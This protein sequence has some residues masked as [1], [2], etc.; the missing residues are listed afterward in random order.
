MSESLAEFFLDNFRARSR[1]CAYRQCRGY[2]MESLAYGDVLDLAARF[3]AE[4]D[5]RKIAKGDR[6]MLWGANGAEWVAAFFGC[7]LRGVVVVP[8]DDGASLDFAARVAQQVQARL[9]VASRAHG[10]ELKSGAAPLL[11]L[12]ALPETLSGRAAAHAAGA[13]AITRSDI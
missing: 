3:A 13:P 10:K 9:W 2:R 8:M 1:E 4:L 12:E 11:E 5:A 7:T 6:I